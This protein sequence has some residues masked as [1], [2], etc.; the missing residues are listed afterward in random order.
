MKQ[1]WIRIAILLMLCGLMAVAPTLATAGRIAPPKI[2]TDKACNTD[3]INGIHWCQTHPGQ[4]YI[5]PY[6][7][8]Y[9]GPPI[10]SANQCDADY[11]NYYWNGANCPH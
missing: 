9:C 3:C 2:C 7:E 6:V 11:C 4:Y 8:E 5:G 10:F 1:V